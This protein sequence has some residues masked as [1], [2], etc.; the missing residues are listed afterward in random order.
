MSIIGTPRQELS[1]IAGEF[2]VE[3]LCAGS[4]DQSIERALKASG[5][6]GQRASPL[7]PKLVMWVVLCLPMFRADSIPAVLARLLSGL[8]EMLL[9]LSLRPVGDDALAH[10]RRRLGVA[11]LRRFFE[12]EAAEVRPPPTFHGLRVWSFD[13]TALTM[14]DTKE[15]RRVFGRVKVSR[16]RSAFPQLKMVALQ[17]VHTRCFRDVR[18]RRWDGSERE[19]AAPMLKHLGEGDLLLIDRGFYGMWLFEAIR[20]R[21]SHFL[22]R[23]PAYVKLKAVRGTSKKS[24]DYLAWIQARLPL[25]EGQKVQGPRG[26][27]ATHRRVR[28]LVRVIEYRIR[29]FERVRVIT[30]ILDRAI[31]PTEWVLEYHRRWD[32]ELAFDELKTHQSSTAQ[33]T[34]R[35]I[36][37]S[38]TPRNVMQEAYAL[39]A[40]YNL[41]RRSM[42]QAARQHRLDPDKISFVGTLRVIAHMLPRMKAAPAHRLLRLYEQLLLDIAEAQI[43]RPRRPRSYPRVVKRKMSNYKLKRPDHCQSSV[44]F[45]NTIRIGA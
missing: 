30:S 1:R 17:D 5:V 40:G 15:N 35:T 16:G 33:G 34:P 4:T 37:R 24:G 20:A 10:A 21:R 6:D 9:C 7:Q 12:L 19:A 28:M 43:D 38:L 23:V 31:S 29:G 13:G 8:R 14:P 26:R 45:R 25:P 3:A 2:S 32:I 41:V 18:F 11:P 42:A 36:F 22:A 39:V 44:N 27:P